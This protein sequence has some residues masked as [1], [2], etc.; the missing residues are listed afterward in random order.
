[1]EYNQYS[2]SV[3]EQ[4]EK[5]SRKQVLFAGIQCVLS[6]AAVVLCLV[7]LLV[8][9]RVVPQIQEMAEQ[10]SALAEQ[11]ETTL[12]NVDALAVSSQTGMEQIVEKIGA[13]DIETLNEAIQNLADA[14]APL[15][16]LAKRWS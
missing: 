5:N 4:L 6:I 8:V 12:A 15:A 10:V 14:V 9:A 16:N 1:M 13:L 2:S 11:A 3:L 7:L